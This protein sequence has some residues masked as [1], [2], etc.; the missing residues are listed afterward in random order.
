M[1]PQIALGVCSANVQRSPTY[2]AVMKYA[3]HEQDSDKIAIE[4]AG[5]NVRN[6]LDNNVAL[7]TMVN[8]LEAGLHY[9]LVRVDKKKEIEA[10]LGAYHTSSEL[11]DQDSA[12]MGLF[13]SEVRPIVHGMI[14]AY[15]NIALEQAGIPKE[16]HPGIYTPFEEKPNLGMVLGMDEKTLGKLKKVLNSTSIPLMTYGQLVGETDLEDNLKSGLPGAV[17][18]V[19]YFMDTRKKAIAEMFKKM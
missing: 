13:Y 8:V 18:Q 10:L 7:D 5:I 17:K 11:S 4:S 12:K 19:Q 1:N 6:I 15:R 2:E 14:A 9:G 16:Y 3:L